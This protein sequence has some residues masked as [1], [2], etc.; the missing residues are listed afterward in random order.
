MTEKLDS[1]ANLEHWSKIF[2][3]RSWEDIL[4]GAMFSFRKER[5]HKLRVNTTCCECLRENT[6]ICRSNGTFICRRCRKSGGNKL[7]FIFNYCSNNHEGSC[8]DDFFGDEIF[9]RLEYNLPK[10]EDPRQRRLFKIN[11]LRL[12]WA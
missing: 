6:I 2:N 7:D 9:E 10:Y 1:V 3:H 11:E 5:G 12:F 8:Y 4:I